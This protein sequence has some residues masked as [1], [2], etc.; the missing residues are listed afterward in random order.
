MTTIVKNTTGAAGRTAAFRLPRPTSPT[1]CTRAS[2]VAVWAVR[3]RQ[4]P[5]LK[6]AHTRALT[7]LQP[8]GAEVGHHFG[9]CR[10]A[11][12]VP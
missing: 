12:G 4:A 7:A 10:R 9:P 2:P 6:I 8:P 11:P 1:T 3:P 5:R